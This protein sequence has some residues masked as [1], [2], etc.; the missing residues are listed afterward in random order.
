[1]ITN[2]KSKVRAIIDILVNRKFYLVTYNKDNEVK[3]RQTHNVDEDNALYGIQ[4]RI[5]TSCGKEITIA[6]FVKKRYMKVGT[7]DLIHWNCEDQEILN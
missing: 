6:D 5:C 2:I 4:G 1:M 7:D 3:F